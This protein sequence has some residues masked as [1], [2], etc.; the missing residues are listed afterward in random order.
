MR[1]VIL[2]PTVLN[3]IEVNNIGFN[4]TTL[5]GAEIHG[6]KCLLRAVNLTFQPKDSHY[7]FQIIGENTGNGY[8]SGS[9]MSLKDATLK[10]IKLGWKVF[11]F[12]DVRDMA[13]WLAS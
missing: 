2:S 6:D 13:S 12:T 5:I 11:H 7:S 10:A 8:F 3:P 4:K 9:R 1:Q